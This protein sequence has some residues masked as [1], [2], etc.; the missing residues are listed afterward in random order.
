MVEFRSPTTVEGLAQ[1]ELDHVLAIMK[2]ALE[3][4]DPTEAIR[5]HITRDGASLRVNSHTYNLNAYENIYVVGGG[6]AGAAMAQTIENILQDHLARGVAVVKHGYTAPTRKIAIHEGGHPLPDPAG[7]AGTRRIADLLKDTTERDLVIA[8]ISGGGSALMVMPVEGIQLHNLQAL[9]GQLL[10]SGATINEINAVRKHLSGVKGGQLARMAAPAEVLTLILSDVVGS[11][12]DVI[13]SGPTAP[14]ASTYQTAWDV[15]NRYNLWAKV[16]SSIRQHLDAGRQGEIDETPKPGDPIFD[17]VTNVIISDNAIAAQAAAE[18]AQALGY[19]T[20]LLSTYV[21]GEAREVAQV[22]AGIAKEIAHYGRPAPRPACVI[23]G[24]ETTVTLQ[25]TGKGGRN[26]EL[27]L[28]AGIAIEGLDNALIAS[29]ATDGTDG[30]TDAAGGVVTDS[31]VARAR[32]EDLDPRDYLH[33]SDSYHFFDQLGDLIITGPTN[34]NVNDLI[35]VFV[36][37]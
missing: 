2:A 15:L 13:A 30:P 1:A 26:M 6:K 36:F 14:D 20:L 21:E 17:Q 27:A 18:Q 7:L 3:A 8:L 11:P 33:R 10:A 22:F 34:T 24:G 32:A 31:T 29:L 5:R 35:F 4:V 37:E 9:T 25:G 23:A 28:A 19:H 16:P 12:L